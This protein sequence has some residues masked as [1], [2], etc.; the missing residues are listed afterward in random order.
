MKPP[1]TP[2]RPPAQGTPAP[3]G[4][5]NLPANLSDG[6][7]IIP[8]DV[9]NYLGLERIEKM[10]SGA[11]EKL[12]DMQ[13]SGRIKQAQPQPSPR[14]AA[15][16]MKPQTPAPSQMASPAPMAQKQ[17]QKAP[18]FNTGGMIQQA[19]SATAPTYTPPGMERRTLP[20]GRTVLVPAGTPYAPGIGRVGSSQQPSA[21]QQVAREQQSGQTTGATT[22]ATV[23]TAPTPTQGDQGGSGMGVGAD[24]PTA[25][26]QSVTDMIGQGNFG[27]LRDFANTPDWAI[28]MMDFAIGGALR[29]GM[30]VPGLAAF[31]FDRAFGGNQ[32]GSVATKDR[33]RAREALG[34]LGIDYTDEKAVQD[35]INNP[36]VQ[37]LSRAATAGAAARSYGESIGAPS[38]SYMGV[39]MPDGTTASVNT[40]G[41]FAVDETG[42][43]VG[44]KLGRDLVA[45]AQ[46]QIGTPLEDVARGISTPSLSDFGQA[47]GKEAAY[48]S[49]FGAAGSPEGDASQDGQSDFGGVDSDT[50]DAESSGA[51]ADAAGEAP[52]GGW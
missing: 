3:G 47:A 8:S 38:G 23:S 31:G 6:E 46:S 1:M 24:N 20:D 15:Q 16:P 2:Q 51:E 44:G 22:P 26:D 49:G 39:S 11:K 18:G 19:P 21:M 12:A 42:A 14:P 27:G 45:A 37:A 52:G 4:Q 34:T 41:G 32:T 30:T 48:G 5:D 50:A 43:V 35:F 9:V 29:G 36:G 7:Y 40:K 25:G 33:E 13:Q 17:A 10:V 28:N